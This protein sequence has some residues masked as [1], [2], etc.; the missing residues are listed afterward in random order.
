MQILGFMFKLTGAP[1]AGFMLRFPDGDRNR[2][3]WNESGQTATVNTVTGSASTVTVVN[4]SQ[5][6]LQFEGAEIVSEVNLN[7]V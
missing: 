6:Q 2:A 1:G 7:K 3:I 4:G 5:K